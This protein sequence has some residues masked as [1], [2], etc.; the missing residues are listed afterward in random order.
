M[1][2]L[3][4]DAARHV[5]Q[6]DHKPVRAVLAFAQDRAISLPHVPDQD[7]PDSPV[8]SISGEKPISGETP[9]EEAPG[10]DILGEANPKP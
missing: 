3:A 1:L 8:K 9:G 2:L 4:Y 6:S 7:T 10:G 5:R